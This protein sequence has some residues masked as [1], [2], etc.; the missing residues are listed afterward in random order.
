MKEQ[1]YTIP[2][3]DA[4]NAGDECPFCYVQREV[5]NDIMDFVLGSCASYMEADMREKTDT[6]GFCKRHSKAMFDY[7]NTL[8]NAWILKTHYMRINGELEK[9]IAGFKPGKKS[10]MDKLKGNSETENPLVAWMQKWQSSCYIC[11]EYQK[12]YTRY[13]DTFV[14]LWKTEEDFRE[15]VCKSKGFCMTH[16]MD[17]CK[18]ADKDL[19]AAELEAFYAKLLPVFAEGMQRLQDDVSWLVEKFDYQNKDADWKNSKDAI[20]RGMQKLK[21]GYPADKP[22]VQK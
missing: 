7:G 11:D 19:S 15:R 3:N 5:E 4:V 18:K 9:Q 13:L 14:Y 17:L 16:F 21:S 2:L 20:E 10:L 8:G 22:H 6:A 1:L 12:T